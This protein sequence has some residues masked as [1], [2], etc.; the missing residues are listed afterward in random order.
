MMLE[1]HVK[2]CVT[3]PDFPEKNFF[4]KNWENG[5]KMGQK[6]GLL[7]ILKNFVIDF[8]YLFLLSI[9]FINLYYLLFS[10][11]NPIFV[12]ILVSEIWAKIFLANQIVGLFNQPYLQ[13]KSMK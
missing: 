10:C 12:K 3:Q 9:I 11:T 7:N 5:P 6:Q 13:K 1:T 4:L 2:S 8:Y